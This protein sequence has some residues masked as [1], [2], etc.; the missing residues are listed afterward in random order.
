MD[1]LQIFHHIF[2]F[3]SIH[4]AVSKINKKSEKVDFLINT[5]TFPYKHGYLETRVPVFGMEVPELTDGT[6]G[7]RYAT[8]MDHTESARRFLDWQ[9]WPPLLDITSRTKGSY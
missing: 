6:L 7:P 3:Q 9:P 5:G 8:E 4:V 1:P 2:S